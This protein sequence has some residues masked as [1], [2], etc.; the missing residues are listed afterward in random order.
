[1]TFG[2]TQLSPSQCPSRPLCPPYHPHMLSEDLLLL[3]HPGVYP[4]GSGLCLQGCVRQTL[5]CGWCFSR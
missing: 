3:E 4:L 1:M 2:E 5:R